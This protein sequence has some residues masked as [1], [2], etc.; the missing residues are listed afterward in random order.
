MKINYITK[1]RLREKNDMLV[2]QNKLLEKYYEDERI[3]T[4][5]LFLD[6]LKVE[7]TNRKLEEEIKKLNGLLKATEELGRSMLKVL[8]EHDLLEKIKL[9]KEGN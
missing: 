8:K 4:S 5:D 1:K 9:K 7:K 2:K 6:K 3:R